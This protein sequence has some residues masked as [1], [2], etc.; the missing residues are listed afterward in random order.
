V[1]DNGARGAE[2][3]AAN[4]EDDGIAAADD[5]RGVGEDVGPALEHEADHA[6]RRDHLIEAPA[7]MVDVLEHLAAAAASVTPAA[8]A[9]DHLPAHFICGQQPCGRASLRRSGLDV[10]GVGGG[11]GGP[12]R[13][14]GEASGEGL[15]EGR[16]LAVGDGAHGLECAISPCDCRRGRLVL[17]RRNMQQ[18]AGLLHHNEPVASL[19]TLGELGGHIGHPIAAERDRHAGGQAVERGKAHAAAIAQSVPQG[20]RRFAAVIE[21]RRSVV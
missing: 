10:G 2:G 19:K 6:E 5:A 4:P 11:D 15:E 18:S 3:I 20:R 17:G 13:A 1:A 8:K 12:D 7:G 9:V 16:D 21:R 14:V